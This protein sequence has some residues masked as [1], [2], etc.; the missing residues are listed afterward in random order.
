MEFKNR[1]NAVCCALGMIITAA[2]VLAAESIN[3]VIESSASA[4]AP[5]PAGVNQG[6]AFDALSTSYPTD[7]VSQYPS[8]R[9][10]QAP[11]GWTPDGKLT[12]AANGDYLAGP[13][14]LVA[15]VLSKGIHAAPGALFS[16]YRIDGPREG[17]ADPKAVYLV[18]I[19]TIEE[20]RCGAKSRC[21]FKAL[22]L[23]DPIEGG[24]I[25]KQDANR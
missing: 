8:V 3:A 9:R 19:G 21:D 23:G 11:K 20:T 5:A 1:K 24:E 22:K 7:M 6:K 2:P 10:L 25:I 18:R 13:G 4:S 12:G 16:V 15:G 17:D 14:D